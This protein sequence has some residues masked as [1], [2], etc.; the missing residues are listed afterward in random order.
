M[1]VRG[2]RCNKAPLSFLSSWPS[3]SSAS[4]VWDRCT[5]S[6]IVLRDDPAPGKIEVVRGKLVREYM[7]VPP[8]LGIAV[9]GQP[10]KQ[11]RILTLAPCRICDPVETRQI[12]FHRPMHELFR[13][14]FRTWLVMDALEKLEFTEEDT[15]PKI[16]SNSNCTQLPAILAFRMKLL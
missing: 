8:A 6:Q 13:T 7:S 14:F 1:I 5:P 15:E 16:E 12:Y 3:C 11:V 4:G 10:E 9:S 2:E